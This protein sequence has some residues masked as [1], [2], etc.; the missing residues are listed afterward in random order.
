METYSVE[1]K[2]KHYMKNI[3]YV[4]QQFEYR[5]NVSK[6]QRRYSPILHYLSCQ[7][8]L[9]VIKHKEEG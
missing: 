9:I 2:D 6:I 1:T 7:L 8:L 5:V 4:Y 3:D